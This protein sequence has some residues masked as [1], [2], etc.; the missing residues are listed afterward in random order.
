MEIV[1]LTL[2]DAIKVDIVGSLGIRLPSGKR[3]QLSSIKEPGFIIW[4]GE[5]WEGPFQDHSNAWDFID[6]LRQNGTESSI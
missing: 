6:A 2:A 1:Y 4:T 5:G 3:V